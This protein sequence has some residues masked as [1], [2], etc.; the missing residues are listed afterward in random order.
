MQQ[1][2]FD[3][4]GIDHFDMSCTEACDCSGFR[5]TN[6]ALKKYSEGPCT[7][8]GCLESSKCVIDAIEYRDRSQHQNQSWD[9]IREA[10]RKA[11]DDYEDSC[12]EAGMCGRAYLC[13]RSNINLSAT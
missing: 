12:R 9:N 7:A 4:T 13:S 5:P 3:G 6:G 10:H 2:P 11:Y 8:V 1:H